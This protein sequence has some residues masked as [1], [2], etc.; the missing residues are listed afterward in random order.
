MIPMRRCEAC[1]QMYPPWRYDQ[2]YCG[3]VCRNVGV[4]SEQRAARQLWRQ[5]GRPSEV[6]VEGRTDDEQDLVSE[7]KIERRA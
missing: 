7:E 5:L 1:G 3:A 6:T 2:R 4:A